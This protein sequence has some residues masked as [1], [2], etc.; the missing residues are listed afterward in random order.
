M[1]GRAGV[2]GI[3]AGLTTKFYDAMAQ[4]VEGLRQQLY[5]SGMAMRAGMTGS[6]VYG[7]IRDFA[8]A[9]VTSSLPESALLEYMNSL[10]LSGGSI[11]SHTTK[12]GDTVNTSNINSIT[13]RIAQRYG[14]PQVVAGSLQ[15]TIEQAGIGGYSREGSR[16]LG[17]GIRAANSGLMG[18]GQVGEFAGHITDA[19]R[20]GLQEGFFRG[21]GHI[22]SA[23]NLGARELTG[24]MRAGMSLSGAANAQ[25]TA[26][27]TV[28]AAWQM[29][30]PED[31]FMFFTAQRAAE[32]G[33]SFTGVMRAMSSPA[34]RAATIRRIIQMSAGNEDVAV[35]M[36]QRTFGLNP[37]QAYAMYRAHKDGTPSSGA[38]QKASEGGWGGYNTGPDSEV[39]TSQEEAVTQE[40]FLDD[41]IFSD[42]LKRNFRGGLNR[43]YD[44]IRGI[45]TP[46]S[47]LNVDGFNEMRGITGGGGGSN[48]EILEQLRQININ[49]QESSVIRTDSFDQSEFDRIG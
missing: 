11:Y 30:R 12:D 48:A 38:L 22:V 29:G 13:A 7:G 20:R 25:Q 9:R 41:Y 35:L 16:V 34:N 8:R 32:P 28:N 2:V 21:S 42:R 14:V 40:T 33:T 18:R 10:G 5:S 4:P 45:T 47:E 31:A 39:T 43:F 19:L 26:Q 27:S 15:G 24:L 6:S 49:L 17:Q 44:F 36:I 23:M 46:R 3:V 37:H 1:L